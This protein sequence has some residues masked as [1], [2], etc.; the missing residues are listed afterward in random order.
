[1]NGTNIQ[2]PKKLNLHV[3]GSCKIKYLTSEYIFVVTYHLQ[4]SCYLLY[5]ITAGWPGDF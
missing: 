1:M 2:F 5:I 4:L 3:D